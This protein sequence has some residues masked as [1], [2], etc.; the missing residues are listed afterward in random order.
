[1]MSIP[2]GIKMRYGRQGAIYFLRKEDFGFSFRY[3]GGHVLQI[4][5]QNGKVI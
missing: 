4:K 1:M 3:S 5:I 2:F